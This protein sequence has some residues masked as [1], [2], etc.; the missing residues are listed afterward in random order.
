MIS[1]ICN[2]LPFTSNNRR[3]KKFEIK[4]FLE[5]SFSPKNGQ[6]W[7]RPDK[8]KTNF[9]RTCANLKSNISKWN[10]GIGIL[11][12]FGISS[13]EPVFFLQKSLHPTLILPA[14][15]GGQAHSNADKKYTVYCWNIPVYCWNIPVYCWKSQYFIFKDMLRF[16]SVHEKG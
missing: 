7:I 5:L 13:Q 12:Q 6:N 1:K 2:Y 15:S 16:Q 14:R 10:F 11:L 4:T 3:P 8:G 9:V